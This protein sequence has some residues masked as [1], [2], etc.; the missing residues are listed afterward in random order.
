LTATD[1]R[2]LERLYRARRGGQVWE[3]FARQWQS[4]E[5]LGA[6]KLRS[7]LGLHS[8]KPLALVCTNVVGDSLALD[9]QVFTEGMAEWLQRTVQHLAERRDVQLVVRVH[10]GELL[11]AGHPSIEIVNNAMADLPEHVTVIPPDSDINTYD[12]IELAHVGLVYTTTV[13]MEMA[14]LGVPV[15][16]AGDAHYRNKGFTHH[17]ES[18]KGYLGTLDQLLAEPQGR[19]LP[20]EQV[21][22]ARRY[23]YRFFFEYPFAYPWHV[24]HFWKD[25]EERPFEEAISL[26][27]IGPYLN[28]L[29]AI[30]GGQIDWSLRGSVIPSREMAG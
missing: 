18:M 12:L 9:R 2:E 22:L 25:L 28:T 20:E 5:S 17:P 21:Q 1:E 15:I 11:G 10:P 4:G 19:R 6:Q 30:V 29:E 13:G 8:E 14:M 26:D 16:V 23:A 27:G 24:I 3:T 7:T